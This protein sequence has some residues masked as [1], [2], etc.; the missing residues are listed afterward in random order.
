M[1]Q[2][3]EDAFKMRTCTFGFVFSERDAHSNPPPVLFVQ[4]TNQFLQIDVP[5]GEVAFWS[6]TDEHKLIELRQELH[7]TERGLH[8]LIL[9]WDGSRASLQL[10]DQTI[11]DPTNFDAPQPQKAN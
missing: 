9:Q 11:A 2:H 7:R 8:T 10:D 4:S 6:M 1:E 3:I 5:R